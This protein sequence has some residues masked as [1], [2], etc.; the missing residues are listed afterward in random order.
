MFAADMGGGGGGP[1]GPTYSGPQQ[2][3]IE[4]SAIPGALVAFRDAY[5]AVAAKV[6]DLRGLEVREWAKDPVSGETA[7]QFSRRTSGDG[8]SAMECLTGYEKQLK[9]VISSLEQAEAQYQALEGNNA[10]LWGKH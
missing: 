5:D 9:Q 1:T 3:R 2:L 6:R 7:T 4:P 10:A 8:D